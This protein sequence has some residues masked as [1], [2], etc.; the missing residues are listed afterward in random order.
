VAVYEILTEIEPALPEGEI[1]KHV[2]ST[3]N[4]FRVFKNVDFFHVAAQA[5]FRQGSNVCFVMVLCNVARE[6]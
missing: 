2:S 1:Q 4:Q 6:M 3:Q 5:L